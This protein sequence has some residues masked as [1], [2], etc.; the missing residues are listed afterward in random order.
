[1]RSRFVLAVVGA[2]VSGS[3]ENR[4]PLAPSADTTLD[5]TAFSVLSGSYNLTATA[6]APTAIALSW[7][8][9]SS[10]EEGFEVH[11]S[12]TGPTGAF[13]LYAITAANVTSASDFSVP[14]STL[15]CYR[16]RAFRKVGRK[17]TYAAFSNTACART[18]ALPPAN[19]NATPASSS[20]IDISWTDNA[21]TDDMFRVER[22]TTSAGPWEVAATTSSQTS[23]R[24]ANR[25]A[26]QQACYRVIAVTPD[27]DSGPSNVDCTAPP[28][29]PTNLTAVAASQTIDLAW[30]DNSAVEAGY[31]IERSDDGVTFHSHARLSANVTQFSD[32]R[33]SS[34]TTYW[35]RVRALKDG[36]FSDLSNVASAT[37]TCGDGPE[38]VCDN[39]VDDDCDGVVD[40]SDPDCTN[41]SG[42]TELDCNNYADDDCDG[43]VD[44]A[45]PDCPAPPCD[46]GCPPGM[47]C[48][49]D[50]YCYYWD[51][52]S[53]NDE[54]GD[55]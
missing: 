29:G 39:G 42:H 4:P 10:H 25:T 54:G 9:N 1:M 13:A 21:P 38:R 19:V 26:D 47:A 53:A 49:P 30:A 36:G 23:Y 45:D 24:D 27:G 55:R 35:Y 16:V 51:P 41:C 3:C 46:W 43:L 6:T 32:Y 33:P 7:V 31:E 20:E 11:R 5:V 14:Q 34:N 15:Y 48:F 44:G 50:G 12:T 17:T 2:L 52:P 28:A 8:D 18:P 37:R 22:A 40:F